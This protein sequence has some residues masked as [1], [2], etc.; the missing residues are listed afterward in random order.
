MVRGCTAVPRAVGVTVVSGFY[1]SEPKGL[2]GSGLE[3]QTEAHLCPPECWALS[4]GQQLTPM[5][6]SS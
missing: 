6:D 3:G 1:S 2:I 4:L 5:K